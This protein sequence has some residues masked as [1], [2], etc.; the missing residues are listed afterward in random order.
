MTVTRLDA[1]SRDSAECHFSFV[2]DALQKTNLIHSQSTAR[3]EET[4]ATD[5]TRRETVGPTPWSHT[6][7]S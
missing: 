7:H 2:R 5:R 1:K 3:S 6:T 4:Y